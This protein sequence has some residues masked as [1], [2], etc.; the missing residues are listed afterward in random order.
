[1]GCGASSQISSPSEY[2]EAP[3]ELV[4][5]GS[6]QSSLLVQYNQTFRDRMSK[7]ELDSSRKETII[8]SPTNSGENVDEIKS[9]DE[10]IEENNLSANLDIHVS[11]ENIEANESIQIKEKEANEINQVSA[12]SNNLSLD[13]NSTFTSDPQNALQTTNLI[14]NNSYNLVSNEDEEMAYLAY[15]N[16]AKKAQASLIKAEAA[17]SGEGIITHIPNILAVT[18]E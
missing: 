13:Y 11:H 10:N 2:N 12:N 1:M 7:E 9:D 4:H 14:Q 3:Y 15:L 18:V 6:V 17:I 16:E 8:K 5:S